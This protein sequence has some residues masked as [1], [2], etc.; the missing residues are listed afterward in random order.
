VS[1][2]LPLAHFAALSVSD[3][4]YDP[5]A[6]FTGDNFR[7]VFG[8]PLFM[9]GLKNTLTYAVATALVVTLLVALVAYVLRQRLSN[10][11]RAT[12]ETA[13]V[14]PF[15]IPGVVLAVGY[16]LGFGREPFA[17]VG[18]MLLLVLAYAGHFI[19]VSFQALQPVYQQLDPNWDEAARIAGARL[20]RRLRTVLLPLLVPGLVSSGILVF[21]SVAKE[22]PLT[23]ML[24]TGDTVGVSSV[25]INTFRDGGFAQLGAI[26]LILIVIVLIA[27]SAVRLLEARMI[28]NRRSRT[29][30]VA[31][32]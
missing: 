9:R 4:W 19:P 1:A 30:G 7:A 13:V 32:A 31:K 6:G 3:V 17:L 18:T 10:G 27:S 5:A 28:G 20:A 11:L 25:V 8:S 24:S 12:F 23:L 14:A 21:M 22:L 29:K 15:A 26:G 16:I 2:W